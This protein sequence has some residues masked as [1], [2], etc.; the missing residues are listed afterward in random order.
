LHTAAIFSRCAEALDVATE[1]CP[2]ESSCQNLSGSPSE[3]THSASSR[4]ASR[5]TCAGWV[6]RRYTWRRSL[7]WHSS[8]GRLCRVAAPCGKPVWQAIVG[9]L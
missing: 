5:A 4:L 8:Y 1:S 9:R 2:P 6:L 7:Y 3:S